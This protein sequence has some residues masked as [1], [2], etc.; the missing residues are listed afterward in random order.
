MNNK[1]SYVYLFVIVVSIS[2]LG[3]AC[4]QDNCN[5]V[6]CLNEGVCVNGKCACAYGYEGEFCEEQWYRKFEGKWLVSEKA[7]TTGVVRQYTVNAYYSRAVD[8]FLVVG[9]P[10][11]TDT[12]VCKRKAHKIFYIVSKR[13]SPEDSLIGGEARLNDDASVT[14]LYSLYADTVET[15]VNITW[16]R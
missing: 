7:R 5:A 10:S 14:G 15:N 2:F 12:V 11:E 1:Y 6:K 13:L 8:S 16:T 3:V 4:V 9:F